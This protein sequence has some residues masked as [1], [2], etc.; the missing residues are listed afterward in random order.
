MGLHSD[1]K[2][3]PRHE[4]RK[5]GRVGVRCSVEIIPRLCNDDG[6]KPVRVKVRDIS[7]SGIGLLT[8]LHIDVG[9]EM[10]CPLPCEDGSRV[11][12][13]MTVRHCYQVSKGLY[14]IGASFDR[15]LVPTSGKAAPVATNTATSAGTAATAV[16][17]SN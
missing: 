10:I 13:V 11:Q 9:V 14:S 6:D 2:M 3:S 12:V 15:S 16:A 8:H 5:E 1:E 17:N 4:K 7:S